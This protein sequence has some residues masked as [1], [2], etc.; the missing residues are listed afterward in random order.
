MGWNPFRK[1][2]KFEAPSHHAYAYYEAL[3]PLNDLL[4][5]YRITEVAQNEFQLELR[6]GPDDEWE[7]I[8]HCWT[9]GNYEKRSSD[10]FTFVRDIHELVWRLNKAEWQDRAKHA[11]ELALPRVIEE[12]CPYD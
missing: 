8:P 9:D 4:Y 7:V 3:W 6:S 12:G 5:M 11:Y 10:T 1:E 2:S